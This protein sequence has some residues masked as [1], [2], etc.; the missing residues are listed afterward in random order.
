MPMAFYSS[1][2]HNSL[3][4]YLYHYYIM[5]YLSFFLLFLLLVSF[6]NSAVLANSNNKKKAGY[7]S[8]KS[9]TLKVRSK[10]TTK[11]KV[12][13]KLKQQQR[14]KVTKFFKNGS[15]AYITSPVEG[16]V[17]AKYLA[18]IGAELEKP[19]AQK[20]KTKSK[21]YYFVKSASVYVYLKPS[22]K[23]KKAGILKYQ[24]KVEVVGKTKNG[25]WFKIGPPIHGYVRSSNLTKSIE[26]NEPKEKSGGILSETV[27]LIKKSIKNPTEIQLGYYLSSVNNIILIGMEFQGDTNTTLITHLGNYSY[28]YEEDNYEEEGSSFMIGAHARHYFQNNTCGFFVGAGL[29]ILKG[30]IKTKE[31]GAS[32][33]TL[34]ELEY[35]GFIPLFSVGYKFIFDSF[36]VEPSMVASYLSGPIKN[37][38]ITGYGLQVGYRF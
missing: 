6:G 28:D 13:I 38:A 18:W 34:E 9:R 14:I 15:W 3:I 24:Q 36:V 2:I 25:E 33:T 10:P 20:Q 30:T 23:S 11:S 26:K 5:R 8:V 17:Y 1:F 7:Y 16:F 29:D 22:S 4:F 19:V 31:I 21:T 37:N 27:A 32:K 35:I 12:L